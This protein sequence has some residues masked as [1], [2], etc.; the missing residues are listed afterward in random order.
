VAEKFQGA[1]GV[2]DRVIELSI[3]IMLEVR[4]SVRKT[5]STCELI[6]PPALF[7]LFSFLPFAS[8]IYAYMHTHALAHTTLPPPPSTQ[9]KTK[10]L[11]PNLWEQTLERCVDFGH[12]FSKIIEMLPGVDIMHGEAV[13]VDGAFPC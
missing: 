4:K 10:E 3:Q 13:N 8:T 1:D 2:A 9:N 6:P 12:T 7:P 5:D 11:G